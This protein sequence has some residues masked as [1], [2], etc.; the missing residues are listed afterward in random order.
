MNK[1]GMVS[2]ART[3]SAIKKGMNPVSSMA[4]K[5]PYG[6]SISLDNDTLKKLG[7]TELPE[8]GDE[9]QIIGVAKVTHASSAS[10]EAGQNTSMELTITHLNLTHE[11]DVEEKSESP[12][13]EKSESITKP[14]NPFGITTR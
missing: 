10:S 12:S 14:G 13:V 8:M 11:D 2:M 6:V 4:S 3:P 7:I 9:Y 1:N 5:Y